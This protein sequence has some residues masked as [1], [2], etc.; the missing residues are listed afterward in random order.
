M[1]NVETVAFSG[2]DKVRFETRHPQTIYRA[3]PQIVQDTGAAVTEINSSTESLQDIFT[4]LMKIHRGE[5]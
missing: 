1:F 4:S 2:K 5:L 3:L